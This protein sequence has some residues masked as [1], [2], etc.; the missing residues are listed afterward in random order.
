ME[1]LFC[2]IVKP[3]QLLIEYLFNGIYYSSFNITLT[4][5]LLSFIISVLCLPL[6]LR[7]DALQ[8]EENEIQKKLSKRVRVIKENFKGDERQ[9]LL[10]TYYRQNNY[11]PFMGLRLS[12]SLLLQIP[13]FLA[14]Y[15]F[16]SNLTLLKGMSLGPISN[17]YMPDGLLKFGEFSINLFPILMTV[18]NLWAGFIYAKDKSFKENKVLILMS[19][20][21]LILLYNSPAALVIYWTF[22]NVFSLIKNVCLR[23]LSHKD[24]IIYVGI[25]SF[26]V[27]T[28]YSCAGWRPNAIP[29]AIL[30]IVMICRLKP[31]RNFTLNFDYKN[32]YLLSILSCFILLG[33]FIPSN[34]VASSPIDFIF[35][36]PDDPVNILK[37]VGTIFAGVFIF[38]GLWIYY[39]SN[40]KLRKI[41]SLCLCLFFVFSLINLLIIKMPAAIL[42]NTLVFETNDISS[43]YIF[44]PIACRI[45]LVLCLAIPVLL[46]LKNKTGL[47][48]KILIF[49]IITCF[50]LSGSNY[51]NIKNTIHSYLNTKKDKTN[52]FKKCINLSQSDKN[53][54]VI[55][56]DRAIN[57]YLPIIFDEYPKL[58]EQFEG[59]TYYP[60]TLSYA[61]YTLFGYLPILGGYEYTPFRIDESN[62]IFDNKFNEAQAVLPV[63]FRLNNFT[64]K[65]INP[66]SRDG[67]LAGTADN[68]DL[69]SQYLQKHSIEVIKT[70][71]T[72]IDELEENIH[73]IDNSIAKRNMVYFSIF[74]SL[75]PQL[76]LRCYE[77]GNYHNPE[78]HVTKKQY[79]E[80]F[81]K[82]YA[83]LLYLPEFTEFSQIGNTFTVFNNKFTHSASLLNYP[84]YDLGTENDINYD[85]PIPAKDY[86][87]LSHYHVNA[88][89]LR[90]LGNY[91]DFLKENKVYDNTRIIIV[92]DHGFTF[93]IKNPRL[94][95]FESENLFFFN[96]LLIVKDFNSRGEFKTSDEFMTNGDVPLLATKDLIKNPVNPFT[97][98]LM[99]DKDKRKGILIKNDNKWM[100]MDYAGKKQILEPADKFHYVK[101]NP[102]NHNN[103][104]LN[105]PYSKAKIIFNKTKG[106]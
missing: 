44:N 48:N 38:W 92:A 93:G 32:L 46:V 6:Y 80:E 64:S 50:I 45:I 84:N 54:M 21:F 4:I 2:L 58:Y 19:L 81:L 47:L 33:L 42:K 65:I 15:T 79:S 104:T 66:L 89:A 106:D 13:L 30:A 51:I 100:P 82:N 61:G 60:N 96:P 1:F 9:F 26:F 68:L 88:A 12:L 17:L 83:D 59:F 57:S 87:S 98:K 28:I 41:L 29:A 67:W 27:Y 22:N 102:L 69:N 3:I 5:L 76:R 7:A 71:E 55:F 20:I 105:I 36:N 95:E 11:H 56:L 74:S 75:S 62:E 77:K 8:E 16:F 14:A 94:G 70:P 34:V 18:I 24:F 23:V 101:D 86:H 91:M 10:Q 85:P 97:H 49:N 72:I 73:P 40:V 63:I 31:V 90:L 99:T 53:V 78:G 25:F 35:T 52:V 37:F 103:W 43:S 39:F